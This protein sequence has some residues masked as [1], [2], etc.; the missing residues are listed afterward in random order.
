MSI[1]ATGSHSRLLT[2]SEA[3]DLLA[4]ERRTVLNW[5]KDGAV[6]YVELPSVGG[7]RQYRI[8]LGGL[9]DALG[10]TYDLAG[11][12]EAADAAAAEAD[13]SDEEIRAAADAT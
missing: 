11:A 6:P 3:A 4:V 5:I 12:L 2:T 13:L 9:L 8:P 7:R 1:T 10:G